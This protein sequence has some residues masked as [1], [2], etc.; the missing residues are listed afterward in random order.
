MGR[1][2]GFAGRTRR[3]TTPERIRGRKF[4]DIQTEMCGKRVID[5]F[6]EKFEESYPDQERHEKNFRDVMGVISDT[7]SGGLAESEF[8]RPPL[9]YTLYCV[10]YHHIFGLS[11][12]QRSTPKKRLTADQKESLREGVHKLSAIISDSKESAIEVP[13][14]YASFLTA[15]SRQTDN[16]LPRKVRFNSLFDEAF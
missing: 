15:C 7:F 11:S 14:K 10:I 3:S 2:K 6:Y 8:S 1:K 16:I 12:M 13:N 4:G 9:F 5:S